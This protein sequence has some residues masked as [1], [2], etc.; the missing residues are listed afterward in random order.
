MKNTADER[1]A[2]E[3]MRPGAIT[4]QGFLGDD[5]R[6]LADIIGHDAEEF[7]RLG[8][9]FERVAAE[10]ARLREEGQKGLGEPVTV[11]GTWLVKAQDARGVLP[12]PWGDGVFHKNGIE[13]ERI[14]GPGAGARLVYSDLSVHM[15][16][17]HRF[18]QGRGHEFRLEPST[19]KAVLGA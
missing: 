3:R 13:V 11:D 16:L 6:S 17:A 14:S 1:M 9:V 7:R 8:L 15:L 2:Y 10:L 4:A 19:I 5:G 18:C 12:C